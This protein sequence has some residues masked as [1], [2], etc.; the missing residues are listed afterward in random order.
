MAM[1]SQYKVSSTPLSPMVD[2]IRTSLSGY[3]ARPIQVRLINN[4]GRS[5]LIYTVTDLD[6]VTTGTRALVWSYVACLCACQST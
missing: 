1:E 6:K 2:Y 3:S 4:F 5:L